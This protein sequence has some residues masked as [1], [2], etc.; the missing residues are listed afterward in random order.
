MLQCLLFNVQTALM[1]IGVAATVGE[2]FKGLLYLFLVSRSDNFL[3]SGAVTNNR[4][5]KVK[6]ARPI[7]NIT[8]A[9]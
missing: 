3:V 7:I 4:H 6:V 8:C 9:R 2:P 5:D 1:A